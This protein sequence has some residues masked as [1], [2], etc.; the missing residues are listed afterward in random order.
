MIRLKTILRHDN[1]NKIRSL[2]NGEAYSLNPI[3]SIQLRIPSIG[4]IVSDSTPDDYPI[5][6]KFLPA[7][8]GL[9]ELQLG[10]VQNILDTFIIA[11]TGDTELGSRWVSNVPS[12][13]IKRLSKYMEVDGFVSTSIV[14]IIDID[15]QNNKVKMSIEADATATGSTINFFDRFDSSIHRAQFYIYNVDYPNGIFWNEVELDFSF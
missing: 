2:V 5:K 1:I 14:E 11:T 10:N 15:R 13:I 7:D 4:V 3:T 12:A 9:I 6:W 8:D